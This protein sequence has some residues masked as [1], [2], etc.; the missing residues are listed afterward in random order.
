MPDFT[1]HP[2]GE[3]WAVLEAG[4]NSPIK[5][6]G[7]REAAELSARELAAGGTVEVLE[8]DPSALA[9]DP[10]AGEPVERPKPDID[11]VDAERIRSLQT[12]L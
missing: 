5:E 1:V 7:T 12:G 11:T 8:E 3:R 9:E 6:F 2:H 4:A 10:S